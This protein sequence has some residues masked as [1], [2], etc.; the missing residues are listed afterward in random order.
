MNIKAESLGLKNTHFV[1]PSGLDAD[2]HYTTALDLA[3][4]GAYA[5]NNE[6]FAQIV[7]TR[8]IRVTYDGVQNARILVNH[9]RLLSSCEGAIGIKTGF[10]KK[11]GRCLVSCVKRGGVCL[12]VCTLND[13][14]DW[15]DHA[16]SQNPGRTGA[17]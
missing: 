7:S 5:M 12:V 2:G 3:R 1:T 6:T 8:K 17:A 10:T 15:N 13:P 14:K 16:L 4:L 9:N 11:C